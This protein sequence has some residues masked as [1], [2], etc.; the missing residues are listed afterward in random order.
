MPP[1]NQA[2]TR[3]RHPPTLGVKLGDLDMRLS[4]FATSAGL[5]V[6]GAAVLALA[7]VQLYDGLHLV[8]RDGDA[9]V[10]GEELPEH[11]RVHQCGDEQ[12]RRSEHGDRGQRHAERHGEG[13]VHLGG[14]AD[15]RDGGAGHRE[16]VRPPR[17]REAEPPEEVD[18]HRQRRVQEHGDEVGH[19]GAVPELARD[20]GPR[21]ARHAGSR[22]EE[23]EHRVELLGKRL[24]RGE[25]LVQ[26]H[27]QHAVVR[28][29]H[30]EEEDGTIAEPH[31]GAQQRAHEVAHHGQ[32]VGRVGHLG[33]AP[34]PAGHPLAVDL[35]LQDEHGRHERVPEPVRQGLLGHGRR[36]A[37]GQEEAGDPRGEEEVHPNGVVVLAPH[38]LEEDGDLERVD[39]CDAAHEHRG[40]APEHQVHLVGH[41][42]E[43]GRRRRRDRFPQDRLAAHAQADTER[44]HREPEQ[45]RPRLVRRQHQLLRRLNTRQDPLITLEKEQWMPNSVANDHLGPKVNYSSFHCKL[46]Q[47]I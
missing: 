2:R 33:Q 34:L 43:H 30:G 41:V 15:G 47:R 5:D 37:D 23:E 12:R 36:H 11:E 40:D 28:Q 39:G 35:E 32:V 4:L 45:E 24:V 38:G 13:V 25:P 6:V 21:H 27:E 14:V 10:I 19:P 29:P 8:V 42:Q 9:D 17:Q 22:H 18:P 7:L 1:G 44:R 46:L 26:R 20:P 16:R 3:S 31:A